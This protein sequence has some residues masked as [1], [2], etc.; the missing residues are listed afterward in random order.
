MANMGQPLYELRKGETRMRGIKVG[1]ALL[2]TFV[3]TT[4]FVQAANQNTI[5]AD[6]FHQRSQVQPAPQSPFVISPPGKPATLSGNDAIAAAKR[7]APG[8]FAP[9]VSVAA[10]FGS[11]D[12]HGLQQRG[13]DGQ[14]HQVGRL[15]AW[16][17]SVQGVQMDRPGGNPK[18]VLEH[19]P[20]AQIHNVDFVVDDATG[21]VVEAAWY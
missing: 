14:L 1:I 13:A 21:Q 16:I 18:A 20:P 5:V 17:V 15:N 4:V 6:L 7:Y 10:R 19:G 12:S 8:A 2:G 9:T 11:V 3:A